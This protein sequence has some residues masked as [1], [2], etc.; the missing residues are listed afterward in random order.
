MNRLK[1][2]FRMFSYFEKIERGSMWSNIFFYIIEAVRPLCL[3]YLSKIII[4]SLISQKSIN[5]VL[6]STIILLTSFMLLSIIAGVLEK[7]FMYHLKCFS[8]KHTMEKALK[9]LR[10][11]FELTEQNEFQNE[12]NA[13]KQFERFIVFSN[14]DFMRKTGTCVGGFIGAGTALYF[15]IDLFNSQGFMGLSAAFINWS[16]LILLIAFNIISF[17]VSKYIYEKFGV[18]IS[19]EVKKNSRYL[20][21]YMDLIYDYRTGKDIRLYDKDLAEKYTKTYLAMQKSSHD[22]MAKFFSRTIGA[23]RLL[24]GALLILVF[25]FVGLKAIY[26]SIQLS[27]VFFFIGAI[28]LF[29]AQIREAADGLT[30]LVPSDKSRQKLLNFLDIDEKKYSGNLSI[31]KDAP[32]IFELKNLSFKYPDQD[33]YALKNINL[34]IDANQKLAMVGKNGSGKTTLIKLLVRLYEPTEGEI[35]LNGVNIK[36]YDYDEY[37]DIFSIVFQDFKLLSLKLGENVAASST[38]D[39]EKVSDSLSKT[40]MED[41][42]KKHGSEAYLYQN[43]ETEGIEASGGEAQK[44]AMARAIYHGGKIFILDE[45]T[46]ALD[47]ISEAEIYSHFDTITSKNN[48]IYISH[49]LSSC[50]FCDQIAVMD[51]GNLVQYGNHDELVSDTR[52]KYYELWSSQAKYYQEEENV[53]KDF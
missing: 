52:G 43:F 42:Y 38:Y 18:H 31:K 33:K 6:K 23:L 53:D 32:L 9:V 1:R 21:T 2:F 44:I 22:F 19:G 3:L 37:I 39:K 36:D 17:Y 46:A 47:P 11:N 13:I 8:K 48:A 26:G 50:K 45:P 25:L 51:E 24:E 29:S 41:F 12:L 5:E 7:R 40:G 49:R 20:K 15:F 27:E 14:S 35:L 16:F 28:N 30:T 34:K 4:E 10:L